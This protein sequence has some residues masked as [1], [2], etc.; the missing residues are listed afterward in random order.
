MKTVAGGEKRKTLGG[1]NSGRR[2]KR[3]PASAQCKDGN[4]HTSNS[5]A[6]GSGERARPPDTILPKAVVVRDS[7]VN[8]AKGR[9]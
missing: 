6:S 4:K 8:Q 1:K 3:L 5:Q 7:I 2:I 9:K